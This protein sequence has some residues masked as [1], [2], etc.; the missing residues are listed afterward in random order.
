MLIKIE[1]KNSPSTQVPV[2]RPQHN[3]T[4][5]IHTNIDFNWD[6]WIS[7]VLWFTCWRR[8]QNT[9]I[10]TT[11][12]PKMSAIMAKLIIWP[13]WPLWNDQYW[14]MQKSEISNDKTWSLLSNSSLGSLHFRSSVSLSKG[15]LTLEF[16]YHWISSSIKGLLPSKVVFHQRSSS[17][18]GCLP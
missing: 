14:C 8:N 2:L 10:L 17:I 9:P 13:L 5:K 4:R 18:K 12:M 16:I 7:A 1:G 6:I 15:C 3:K 11:F